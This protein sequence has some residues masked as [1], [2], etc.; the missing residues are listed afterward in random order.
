MKKRHRI[1]DTGAILATAWT[2]AFSAAAQDKAP[3]IPE[4]KIVALETKLADKEQGTSPARRRLAVKRVIREGDSLL[5]TLFDGVLVLQAG[6][7]I[8]QRVAAF[9][10]H[11]PVPVDHRDIV[12]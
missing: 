8:D 7:E 2:C 4:S 6:R 9:G 11:R 3:P 1:I 12:G 5:E 10:Q